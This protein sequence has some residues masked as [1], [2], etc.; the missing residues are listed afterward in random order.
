MIELCR[1]ADMELQS[2][3]R[4]WGTE[5]EDDEVVEVRG[6]LL[7]SHKHGYECRTE[8]VRGK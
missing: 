6:E 2:E 1:G 7:Q 4:S 8:G 5:K 3:M